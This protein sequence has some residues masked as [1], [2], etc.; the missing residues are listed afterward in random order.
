MIKLRQMSAMTEDLK[1]ISERFGLQLRLVPDDYGF[2]VHFENDARGLYCPVTLRVSWL[3]AE[4]GTSL[5]RNATLM[6]DWVEE[7][8]IGHNGWKAYVVVHSDN[9][10]DFDGREDAIPT[11]SEYIELLELVPMP[12]RELPEV[13]FDDYF[14][15][16]FGALEDATDGI[17]GVLIE[18]GR[19]NGV[20]SYSFS[21]GT[22]RRFQ[23]EFKK[24]EAILSVDGERQAQARADK[25]GEIGAM[26]SKSLKAY[27]ADNKRA[28]SSGPKHR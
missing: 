2:T 21:D 17:D 14:A 4:R 26:V 3:E 7:Q 25:P 28:G 18:C 23:V 22:G 11:I 1:P 10:E 12:S 5:W 27:E 13:S 24:S 19:E 6:Q 8:T 15:N 20:E 16:A 9:V